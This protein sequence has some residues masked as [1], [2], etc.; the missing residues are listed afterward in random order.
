M[1]ST[2]MYS[3]LQELE[4][5]FKT[6]EFDI[7]ESSK[8]VIS[9]VKYHLSRGTT[10]K[11]TDVVRGTTPAVIY[12][13]D[14]SEQN[15]EKLQENSDL[16]EWIVFTWVKKKMSFLPSK[17]FSSDSRHEMPKLDLAVKESSVPTES[18]L[19]EAT[20]P[21]DRIIDLE[22]EVILHGIN[23]NKPLKGK[24]DTGAEMSSLH[25]TN[26]KINKG[27]N[28][29]SFEF[30]DKIITMPFVDH[31]AIRTADNGIEYRPIV[32]FDVS[33]PS[34]AESKVKSLQKIQFNLNDRSKM[35]DKLLLGQNFIKAG[36]FVVINSNN[37]QP[38]K[39]ETT[40]EQSDDE[41]TASDI[42][43]QSKKQQPDVDWKSLK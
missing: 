35:P 2:G 25:A 7:S 39:K 3:T 8:V 32:A 26:V 1:S 31:I 29:V 36:N 13:V 19:E 27:S 23:D 17:V 30:N 28:I 42:K 16:N 43:V 34:T 9:G 15:L 37:S 11:M 18:T 4:Q 6:G 14:P 40:A 10:N 33:L 41:A 24:V 21:D 12:S 22:A 38:T 20:I 5:A